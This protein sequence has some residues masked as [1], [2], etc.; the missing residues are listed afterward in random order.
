MDAKL[1][2]PFINA[3]TNVIGTMA[4]LEPRPGKPAVKMN[5]LSWGDISGIIGLTGEKATGNMVVSFEEK[6]ILRI[7]SNMLMEEFTEI[8]DDVV[9][10]V[11]EITNMI[12]GGAKKELEEL[13]YT[14]EMA[15]P[16][17]MKGK[18]M[19]ITQITKAPIIVIPFETTAGT[20]VVEANLQKK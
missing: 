7:V 17:I 8:T 18:N 6:C 5:K 15:I 10:A 14:F 13:G 19:E 20:F 9:D 1:I 3:T 4:Q 16:V 2:N 11:G 12:S